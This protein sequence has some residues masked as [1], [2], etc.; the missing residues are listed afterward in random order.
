MVVTFLPLQAQALTYTFV[1]AAFSLTGGGSGTIS[2]SFD[3]DGTAVTNFGSI[4]ISNWEFNG[5][6]TPVLATYT[7]T[8]TA[9]GNLRFTGIN[10]S[11]NNSPSEFFQINNILLSNTVETISLT[12][13][14][15]G[16]DG[17]I[18]F[19]L[20]NGCPPTQ[21]RIRTFAFTDG[22]LTSVPLPLSPVAL[23]PLALAM[24]RIRK[25]YVTPGLR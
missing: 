14:N 3:Y 20:N 16:N 15:G 25:R 5:S 23:T 11:A 13:L 21:Y 7:G 9:Q 6:L 22:E 18:G 2:G 19:C 17:E 12:S 8:T 10:G 4:E 24:A 1:N